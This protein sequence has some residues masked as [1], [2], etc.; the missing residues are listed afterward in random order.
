ME[1]SRHGAFVYAQKVL[2][3]SL[4]LFLLINLLSISPDISASTTLLE[5]KY[6]LNLS[7]KDARLEQV[8]DA[9][10]K[11]SGVKIAYSSDELQKDR[12]VSVDIQTSDILTALRSVLGDGY[13][14]KQIEDYIAIARKEIS[15]SSDVINNTVIDDRIWTI[16][17]QVLENSE[18]P[19]PLPGVNILIKG[20]SLGTIS[21]GN[22]YFTI[23]AKRGDI[24]IF[25]YLG[26]KDYE[27]VVSRAISNLTV[28]L[29][30]DSEELDEIVVTGISEEKRVN[31]VSAVSSLDVTKNL[32]TK[33]ITSLSQSLQG[34]ITGLNV[35]QSSGLPGADAAAI[36]IRG[37]STLGTSDPLVLV[38]GI[39]MDMNQLDPNTIESVTVLKDAA[40]ASIWGARSANGV[41]VVTTKKGKK[42]KVQVDVQ[43]FVRIGTNPDLEYIMNQADSRTMV[44]YEMRA[45]ENNW[46]MAAWEYAPIFSKIQNSLTL[47]QELY[48]ANKYQGL[49]KEEMEQGLERL[50]NTSNRQQLKDYLMQTQLLQQYNVSIS[51]GTERMSNYMS[52][53]YEKNDESTIKRGYE[54]FMINYNNSYKVT[55]WLTANLITTL[56]RKDQETSG[57]TIGEFSNLSPYEMLLN[58]DGS[59]ATNLNVYN[60]AE[61]E[62]L[63]LEKLPYSDWS[64]NMLREVRGR[65]Y[66]TT[67][68]MYRVQLGLNAQII[69]GLNYDMRVQYES[70]SSEYKNYDSEDTFYAR[71]LVNS[72]TEYN[73]ET[74]EV[75]VSRIPKGGVLRSGK[76][77]Y[78]NYVFRNQLNYNNS[79]AEKHEISALAGIEISQYDTEGTVNPYVY[80]YNK[81]KNT[82]SVPPYG[83]GSNVDSFKNFFGN[84]ATIEGGN[85]SYSLRCDR[86][87]SYYTNIG[88]VY[89]GKYGASFSARG[90]G[91]NFVSDDPSLRWSPMWSVGAKW[92]IGKEEFIKDID[93]INY[94]NLRATYGINGNAEKSTSPLTLVSVGSSVNSTTGTITGNISSFGNPSLRWEKT[95]TTNIG[96]DFDLFRSKLSGKLDFYNRKS[97]DVIGQVTIPSVYGTSTQKFN[98]AEILNRGVEL[99]LTGNFHIPSVDLGIRSTVTY[100]YNYNKILKLYYPALYC[101]ELVEADTHVEGR[102]VGSLYS[103]DFLGT[104]N[105]IPYVIGANGDKISMNDVSVH[106][107]SLGLD[108]LHYSGT[109]IPPHTFGW[110][111]QFTWNNFSLYVYLTGN[112]G[113]IFR[114]PTAGSIPSVGSGKTFVSSSIKD[115]ADSDGTLYPTWPLKD[116]SNFYLWDRYTPN[117]E[118][119]VQDASFIR[120]KEINL[121]YNLSKKL[122]GKLHLRGA[123]LFVQARNLGLIY[124][125]NDYGYDP[126]W[127]LGSNKPSATIAFGAN[128]NF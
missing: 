17:G 99:E 35:T 41:I 15:D 42:D 2:K 83:Y 84:S 30:S 108:I 97:K 33:P 73:N 28:S 109:T 32:S 21:D 110:S 13:S 49:S 3:H 38:D 106:N 25:K 57:V 4:F 88:Y 36:K 87:V 55:K 111:N 63:P 128:I 11:Q 107:R 75:G 102:P 79:F 121:E 53:M 58:E 93:W 61:L 47:A 10:M 6:T 62:K 22:G 86:Y 12:V 60:R 90:D 115:F 67:N 82:S 59:Y 77:E 8:L 24:L 27:Y 117:L 96:V 120:L 68:T 74:Q 103:Y 92:N 7:F 112:F 19:Y 116:E 1:K 51:G 45:F 9:I 125:A 31:S 16:Q 65:E 80:G 44:D 14:F 119:F 26:F 89:D 126:E 122:A 29:N 123:K 5:Q 91:S 85:T 39:P 71:N 18:P 34:G 78:S 48:Y 64:Y 94:L 114:A 40:A 105:G 76:T 72:Y 20:T 56:Q 100:A 104:E 54:K 127:L 124:C 98:N 118:Y 66:K 46:K 113:G 69:K 50:R 23:K 70:T 101:Y 43:A 95:Y 52:L 81:E 37:I